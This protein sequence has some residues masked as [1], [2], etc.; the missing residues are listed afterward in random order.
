MSIVSNP[1][2]RIQLSNGEL[3]SYM[4]ARKLQI[5]VNRGN[6][7]KYGIVNPKHMDRVVDT[8]ELTL[9]PGKHYLT[10]PEMMILSMLSNYE[11]DRPIYFT[12]MGGDIQLDLKKYM[13]FDG[14]VYK[15]V[16][17]LS[18][19]RAD[20]SSQM[21]TDFMYEQIMH[22]W[23]WSSFTHPL[24]HVDYQNMSTFLSFVSLRGIFTQTARVLMEEGKTEQAIEVLDKMQE[25]V[26]HEL[27]PLHVT[28][29]PGSILNTLA[30]LEAI[31]IYGAAGAL[32]KAEQLGDS[33]VEEFFIALDFFHRPSLYD[34]SEVETNIQL[35]LQLMNSMEVINQEKVDVYEK[36]LQEWIAAWEK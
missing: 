34:E 2:A 29:I 15:L 19:N 4:P 33:M 25:V 27:F 23:R 36:R 3:A 32:E 28:L 21:D 12:S 35:L 7:A 20:F 9:S 5:P 30:L 18:T 13:Q 24:M 1:K 8:L 16:P 14:F 17:I 26:K 22:G 31:D 10:K 6:V 11:W